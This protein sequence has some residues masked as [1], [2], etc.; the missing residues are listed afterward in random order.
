MQSGVQRGCEHFSGGSKGDASNYKGVREK[1]FAPNARV[2]SL[3]PFEKFLN[4]PLRRQKSEFWV[5]RTT[6]SRNLPPPT[7]QAV[8]VKLPILG[9]GIFA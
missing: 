4:T 7:P 1:N 2:R 5:V 9:G 6:E 3:H 8:A